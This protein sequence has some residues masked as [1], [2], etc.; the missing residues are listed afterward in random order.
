MQKRFICRLAI[1]TVFAFASP[2]ETLRVMSF[3]VRYPA[4]TDGPNRWELR[5]DVLVKSDQLEESRP[6][7]DPGTVLRSRSAHC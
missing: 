2:A 7:R 1:V 4:K 3:N 6:D 5:K